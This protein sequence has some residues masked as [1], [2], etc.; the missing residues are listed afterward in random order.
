MARRPNAAA[1]SAMQR[2][3]KDPFA[4]GFRE[5]RAFA[6]TVGGGNS[7]EVKAAAK[8]LVKHVKRQ[9]GRKGGVSAPGEPPRRQTGRLQKS[10]A[11]EVRNGVRRVGTG[12]F[13]GYILEF[14][15]ITG[16]ASADTLGRT[17]RASRRKSGRK[18]GAI[19]PRPFMRPALEAAKEEMGDVTVGELRKRTPGGR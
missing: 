15:S 5:L 12:Y 18:R 13:T 6:T 10:I 16:A 7:A 19:E 1:R 4:K 3:T 11:S 8:V 9:L 2:A 14:G 17:Q